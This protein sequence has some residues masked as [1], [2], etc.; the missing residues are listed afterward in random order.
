MTAVHPGPPMLVQLP[1]RPLNLDDVTALAA[2]DDLHRYELDEGTL[3]VMPPADTEH[4]AIVTRMLVWLVSHGYDAE[5]VLASPGVQIKEQSGGRS[6]ALIVLARPIPATVWV[7]PG[8]VLLVV[9]I[10]SKG[11]ERLDRETKPAEYA[12]AGITHFWRIE[13]HGEGPTAHLY[14][15]GLDERGEPAYVGHDAMLLVD[16]LR[17]APPKLT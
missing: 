2:A 13:R 8:D 4:A 10:V 5:R 11:S 9:E 1:A 16:L 6:P 14:R 12:R 3:L 15:V 17:E 7:D